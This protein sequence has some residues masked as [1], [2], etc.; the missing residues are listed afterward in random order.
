MADEAGIDGIAFSET[1]QLDDG[2][3]E[4]LLKRRSRSTVVCSLLGWAEQQ[5]QRVP[6]ELFSS[7]WLV[8]AEG[9]AVQ[10]GRWEWRLMGLVDASLA[11]TLL[12]LTAP[13]MILSAFLIHLEV[14]QSSTAS[15][16][17]GSTACLSIHIWKPRPM[18]S[19][20]EVD[21]A[22]WASHLDPRMTRMGRWLRLARLDE[23]PQLLNVLRGDMSLIG[24]GPE[25]PEMELER[26]I[27][28]YRLLH[29]IRPGLSGWAQVCY[30]YGASVEDILAKLSYDLFCL[31]SVNRML[32]CLSAIVTICLVATA[33]GAQPKVLGP[34]NP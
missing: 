1:A 28:N 26:I 14:A 11:R 29:L 6:T 2:L 19:C 7:R 25:R 13:L 23:L 8:Q 30:P 22:R 32:E 12:L 9:F 31:R 21:A 10:I 15:G 20:A 4:E 27:P 16:G 33:M 34:V 5:L 3:L 18:L 24:L 17:Q